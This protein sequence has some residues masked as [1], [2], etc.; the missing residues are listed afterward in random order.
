MKANNY[1]D[2]RWTTNR[3]YYN[4]LRKLKL[5][6]ERDGIGCSYCRYNRGENFRGSYYADDKTEPYA[7]RPSMWKGRAVLRWTQD[8]Y[9]RP[10]WKLA[11]KNSRQW[12]DWVWEGELGGF[13]GYSRMSKNRRY[14]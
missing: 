8:G 13:G 12:M 2:Y 14:K 5:A 4:R 11:S 3:T 7:M 10:N 1:D 9:K 6:H